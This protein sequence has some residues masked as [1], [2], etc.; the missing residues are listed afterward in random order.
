MQKKFYQNRNKKIKKNGKHFLCYPL[1]P[2][3]SGGIHLPPE[4]RLPGPVQLFRLNP[5]GPLI[6]GYHW[7]ALL[8]QVR[9]NL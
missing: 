4:A 8:N 3:V 1:N 5:P 7:L 9:I 2:Q 6:I